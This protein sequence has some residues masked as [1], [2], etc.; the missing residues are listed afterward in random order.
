M[1][2]KQNTDNNQQK[3]M[4]KAL[5]DKLSDKDLVALSE[6]RN[7]NILP[8]KKKVTFKSLGEEITLDL[9]SLSVDRDLPLFHYSLILQYLLSEDIGTIDNTWISISD[10]EP[11]DVARGAN[12][13]RQ[14]RDIIAS[15]F[16]GKTGK[17]IKTALLSLDASL[18]PKEKA[19]ISAIV[20]LFPKYPLLINLWL[21]DEEFPASGK[22]LINGGTRNALSLEATGTVAEMT[23]E[24]LASII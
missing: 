4:I 22:V 6:E 2:V 18:Q 21:S 7:F 19:D 12:F 10:T 15:G 13:D 8:N 9:E 1:Q 11:G 3:G 23:A 20:Y 24:K 5:I 16:T 17:D 14:V